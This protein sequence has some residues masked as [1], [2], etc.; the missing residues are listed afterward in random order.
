MA[1]LFKS[2]K[3]LEEYNKDKISVSK[4]NLTYVQG[5]TEYTTTEVTDDIV[6]YNKICFV[7]EGSYI[8]R[9]GQKY[10]G[11]D[12]V[13]GKYVPLN[14]NK[15]IDNEYM[16]TST[17]IFSSNASETV[18]NTYNYSTVINDSSSTS[19]YIDLV[20][21]VVEPIN[22][23]TIKEVLAND[24]TEILYTIDANPSIIASTSQTNREITLLGE[25]WD[26][27]NSSNCFHLYFNPTSTEQTSFQI[28]L[29]YVNNGSQ[30]SSSTIDFTS[31]DLVQD[32]A[33]RNIYIFIKVT[34]NGMWWSHNTATTP[35]DNWTELIEQKDQV[36]KF[37]EVNE[38]YYIGN[39]NN[40]N[41]D[42]SAFGISNYS[43]TDTET[44]EVIHDGLT[45]HYAS[46]DK[47]LEA[48]Q[49]G[50]TGYFPNA[51]TT[52]YGM[53]TP[54]YVKDIAN[55][56]T[57]VASFDT[58]SFVQKNADGTINKQE[59]KNSS[60]S[61]HTYLNGNNV[62]ISGG[63]F[64]GT[65]LKGYSRLTNNG[66]EFS[67]FQDGGT[68]YTSLTTVKSNTDGSKIYISTYDGTN[69]NSYVKVSSYAKYDS[70]GYATYFS[71]VEVNCKYDTTIYGSYF[72]Q[73]NDSSPIYLDN[74]ASTLIPFIVVDTI[75]GSYLSV[76]PGKEYHVNFSY[77]TNNMNSL[78][79]YLIDNY[80]GYSSEWH[81]WINTSNQNSS[82]V[83]N[84]TFV[85][86]YGDEIVW[87]ETPS[88]DTNMLYEISIKYN[89][90]ISKFFGIIHSWSLS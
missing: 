16:P 4:D 56:K 55:L 83:G 27:W 84:I 88:F 59:V 31:D 14:D 75:E 68:S 26:G 50:N 64:D 47:D 77:S 25:S 3:T 74:V 34:K 29:Q 62:T 53:M 42:A 80:D 24:N 11:S 72:I 43:I 12:I 44:N 86:D 69:T 38:H 54:T 19:S 61:N 60:S 13:D 8:F 82:Y 46:D 76:S 9:N 45:M 57:A 78:E 2:Y 40:D 79:F 23:L 33:N 5:G 58:N 20:V 1:K 73:Y 85:N 48:T 66:F 90:N 37:F 71:G 67:A 63:T 6:T 52:H 89:K 35:T 49:W 30:I 22:G 17:A 15:K 87:D 39:G 36:S 21:D 28:V 70:D 81:I 41:S 51:D 65:A 32:G 18:T 10:T 7:D